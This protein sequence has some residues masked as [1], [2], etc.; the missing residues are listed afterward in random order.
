MYDIF[1]PINFVCMT[2]LENLVPKR[3]PDI[4]LFFAF[5][6]EFFS[7][8]FA[9][10]IFPFQLRNI[11]EK[12]HFF[13]HGTIAAAHTHTLVVKLVY[14]RVEEETEVACC[15]DS[16]RD[17]NAYNRGVSCSLYSSLNRPTVLNE[18]SSYV[19]PKHHVTAD[20]YYFLS[21]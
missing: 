10:Y 19:I 1:F 21:Y 17:G 7:T 8:I 20:L 18:L 11:Q 2:C 6:Y 13:E 4:I 15:L 3:I 9:R 12:K 14:S 5:S 16:G